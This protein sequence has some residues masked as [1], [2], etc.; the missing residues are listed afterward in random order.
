LLPA[1]ARA[2]KRPRDCSLSVRALRRAAPAL[3]ALAAGGALAQPPASSGRHKDVR[4]APRGGYADPSLIIAAELAYDRLALEKGQWTALSRIV[5]KD[6]VLFQPGP[7]FAERWLKGQRD[8]A[9]A[10]RWQT[11]EVFMAC[12]GSV[13]VSS[14]Q[15]VRA[16]GGSEGRG[17][18][19]N[20]WRRDKQGYRLILSHDGPLAASEEAPR[21]GREDEFESIS[22]RIAA[23]P[24]RGRPGGAGQVSDMSSPMAV[25]LDPRQPLP[26]SREERAADG[27]LRWRWAV[28]ANGARVLEAWMATDADEVV[29][30]MD[31]TGP[32]ASP[33]AK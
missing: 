30:V 20:I 21:M 23:C 15:W 16:G 14:G 12:D 8:P 31:R 19:S 26:L 17:W 2:W 5:A 6:A 10:L 25:S 4:D 29:V 22:A 24:K 11:H 7:V 18:Y 27:S 13:A 33:S 32:A 3:L 9:T 28:A 1:H